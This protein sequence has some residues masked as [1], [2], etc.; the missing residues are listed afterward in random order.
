MLPRYSSR[1]ISVTRNDDLIFPSY[2]LL[3]ERFTKLRVENCAI[4]VDVGL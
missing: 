3:F 1:L 4:Y 2:F